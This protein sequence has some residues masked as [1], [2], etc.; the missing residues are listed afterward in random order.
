MD[1][2]V[3]RALS[4]AL[5]VETLERIATNPSS[6]RQIASV[7]GEPLGR[8]AYHAAVLHQ[9]GCVKPVEP[10]DSN[11]YDRVYE[12]ATLMPAPPRLALSDS[13]RGHALASVLQRIVERGLAALEAGILGKR[14]D[15]QAS[16]ESIL[17]DRQGW[18]EAQSILAEAA[19]RIE[20]LEAEAAKRLRSG[21]EPGMRATI[22]FVAFESAPE[23][24][25][26]S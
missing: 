23:R 8:I 5:R 24:R 20:A 7:T 4:Q 25:P 22:A 13:T 10:V 18:E 1:P 16:C 2:Q 26:K 19:E 11:P 3:Q 9:T 6:P 21:G 14:R 12:L 15:S 17:V